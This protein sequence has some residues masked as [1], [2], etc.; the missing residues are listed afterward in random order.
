MAISVP[1]N[2][3][4]MKAAQKWQ[5]A[6]MAVKDERL[7]VINELFGAINIIKMYAWELAFGERIE[8]VRARELKILRSYWIINATLWMSWTCLPTF[9]SVITFAFYTGIA[10]GTLDADKAFTSIVLFS[11]L[12]FPLMM[13]PR[14]IMMIVDWNISLGRI[15]RFL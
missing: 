12:R 15:N 1:F 9:T 8:G 13:L 3:F 11:L 4:I 10:G 2:T 14:A 6:I 5:K 7:K